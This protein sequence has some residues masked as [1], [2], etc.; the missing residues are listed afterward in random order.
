MNVEID[1]PYSIWDALNELGQEEP[2]QP[3]NHIFVLNA[4]DKFFIGGGCESTR[5]SGPPNVSVCVD[6][7]F[8]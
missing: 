2:I 5:S 3:E 4:A 8:N 1:L 6:S 7:P